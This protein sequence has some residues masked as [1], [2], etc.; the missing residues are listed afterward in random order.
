[1]P[2]GRNLSTRR[3]FTNCCSGF[4][5]SF[6]SCDSV[7]FRSSASPISFPPPRS[8]PPSMTLIYFAIS[9]RNTVKQIIYFFCIFL[10]PIN[11]FRFPFPCARL[12]NLAFCDKQAIK[13]APSKVG[14]RGEPFAREGARTHASMVLLNER[15]Q[16]HL[17]KFMEIYFHVGFA[18]RR[19][20]A[21]RWKRSL[22][23]PLTRMNFM[24]EYTVR[25]RFS[26]L[27]TFFGGNYFDRRNK[28]ESIEFGKPPHALPIPVR[29]ATQSEICLICASSRSFA[30][31]KHTDRRHPSFV[32]R[33]VS[34]K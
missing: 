1:M 33:I 27:L 14:G 13:I 20:R 21:R 9:P 16:K 29:R 18:R 31:P 7:P 24:Y 23:R 30:P 11:E 32:P 22:E 2:G 34:I 19:R 28:N 12:C 15:N 8:A 26:L 6:S 3:L 5:F 25:Y 17:N 10:P 4:A